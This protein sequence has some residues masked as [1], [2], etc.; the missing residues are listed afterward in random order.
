M[1]WCCLDVYARLSP[2][3]KSSDLSISSSSSE[4]SSSVDP[5]VVVSYSKTSSKLKLLHLLRLL[6]EQEF[7]VLEPIRSI[8]KPR[9]G[10]KGDAS[11]LGSRGT[12]SSQMNASFLCKEY[13]VRLCYK[14]IVGKICSN[15]IR[16]KHADE[17]G[18]SEVIQAWKLFKS[19]AD[20]S[21]CTKPSNAVPPCFNAFSSTTLR[22]SP[23][24][25]EK[26]IT[27]LA[28]EEAIIVCSEYNAGKWLLGLWCRYG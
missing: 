28:V 2:L 24:E 27:F 3:S 16:S 14:V 15:L 6:P 22:I 5:T 18:T 12:R 8:S 26:A 10:K 11:I 21:N 4:F 1:Y 17:W 13:R 9:V 23:I 19:S 7:S 20:L 25:F